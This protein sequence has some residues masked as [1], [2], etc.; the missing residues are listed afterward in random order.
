[1]ER[2]K[3]LIACV[4]PLVLLA[5]AGCSSMNAYSGAAVGAAAGAGVGA[6]VY[7]A[8]VTGSTTLEGVTVGL[9]GGGLAGALVGNYLEV[10]RL[11]DRIAELERERDDLKAQLEAALAENASL[12]A[13]I[14]ELE[15]E[16]ARC[17]EELGRQPAGRVEKARFT[18]AND[19]LFAPGKAKLTS[20]GEAALD[21]VLEKLTS[22]HAGHQVS[23][24]G[25]TDS[26]PIRSSGWKSNW[27]LGAA[28]AM[29][30]LHHLSDVHGVSTANISASTFADTRPAG[31]NATDEG[32]AAN[33]RVEIVV[34][35]N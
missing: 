8:A 24:E 34:Y 22:E 12:K 26:D 30:V 21:A 5:T 7:S 33:R 20:E 13:R 18:L 16:L 28:R 25:H 11:K 29:A 35:E 23:V 32:K 2:I 6:A 3:R 9:L 14:A 31:D 4:L 1:M 15:A 17:R 10:S 27:E 19:I